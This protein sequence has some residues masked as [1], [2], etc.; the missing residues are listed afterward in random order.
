MP[1]C[2][3]MAV[4]VH[5]ASFR[6]SQGHFGAK[7]RRKT[8]TNLLKWNSAPSAMAFEAVA[9]G[10]DSSNATTGWH[11]RGYDPTS[12]SKTAGLVGGFV[13]AL[14]PRSEIVTD[15]ASWEISVS[16]GFEA[17]DRLSKIGP[18]FLI[19]NPLESAKGRFSPNS[20]AAALFKRQAP[21]HRIDI[22]NR[23][24]TQSSIYFVLVFIFF[25]TIDQDGAWK[26]STAASEFS[27]LHTQATTA[28]YRFFVFIGQVVRL[29][30]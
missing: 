27:E 1:R 21:P 23:R 17:L 10:E 8:G 14:S 12:T 13:K 18:G 5:F 15:D 9:P 20:L 29:T 4:E 19:A 3:E 6:L 28:T 7:E 2:P 11:P 26:G 30:R 24:L 16:N 25:S 22:F